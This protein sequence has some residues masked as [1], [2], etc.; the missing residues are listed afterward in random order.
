MDIMQYQE[1]LKSAM[2]GYAYHEVVKDDKGKVCDYR[3]LEV[4]K[5]FVEL[6]GQSRIFLLVR[7]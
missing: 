6:T 5:T 4:N 2:F 7:P 1:I 3:F